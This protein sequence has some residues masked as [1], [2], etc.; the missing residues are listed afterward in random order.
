MFVRFKQKLTKAGEVLNL[1][2]QRSFRDPARLGQVRSKTICGL[3]S[4]PIRPHPTEASLF[5]FK[6]DARLED[7]S[8]SPDEEAKIRDSV[9]RKIPRP[10]TPLPELVRL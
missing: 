2:I 10:R 7:L 9:Q 8:L 1:S 5:W 4:V 3:G 6:L